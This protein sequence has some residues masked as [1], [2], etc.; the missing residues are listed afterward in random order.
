MKNRQNIII[1]LLVAIVVLLG[2]SAIDNI[3]DNAAISREAFSENYHIYQPPIPDSIFFAGEKV[4]LD[5]FHVKER[6]DRELLV[7]TYWQSNQ[8]LLIKR[9]HR[10]FPVIEQ[11]LQEQGVP[12]DFKYLALIE[13]SF[14]D[15][16]SP[17]GAK[18]FWQFIKPTAQMYGLEVNDKVDE[19][20]NLRKST[21]AACKYLKAMYAQYG[22]WTLAA[23]GYNTGQKN[24]DTHISNQ[25]TK[26]YYFLHLHPETKRYIFRILAEKIIF[27]N[28]QSY[29]FYIQEEDMYAPLPVR[30]ITVDT[31]ITDLF[32]FSRKVNV[33]YQVL[34]MYNPW[35]V[36]YRTLPNKSGKKYQ[37]LLPL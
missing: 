6:L 11:I 25:G 23:A 29:G 35:I 12:D 8:M 20:L 31:T 22:S 2:I 37:I 17:A 28:P 34:K 4:P 13:S 3:P 14:T 19:R 24:I 21:I 36:D 32:A 10:W 18:G 1:F 30:E 27:S 26:N 5:V 9:A 7:N 15:V 16:S 33:S